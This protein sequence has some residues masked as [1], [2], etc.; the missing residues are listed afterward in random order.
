MNAQAGLMERGRNKPIRIDNVNDKKSRGDGCKECNPSFGRAE[1]EQ[2]EGKKK[3][4]E[5]QNGHNPF[6]TSRDAMQVP[7]D[8]LRQ[9]ARINDEQLAERH[10]GPKHDE[11]Q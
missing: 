7:T 9:I 5:R 11:S 3:M 4:K 1:Q 8:L 10:V 2:E 6:P